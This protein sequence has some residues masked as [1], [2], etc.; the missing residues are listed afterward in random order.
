MNLNG[1]C[2]MYGAKLVF[3][4]AGLVMAGWQSASAAAV[5]NERAGRELKAARE[6]LHELHREAEELQ[7]AGRNDKAEAVMEKA[8]QLELRLHRHLERQKEQK[9]EHG[10]N[11][12]ATLERLEQ[13]MAALREL[14]M[15]DELERLEHIA[16]GLRE[17]LRHQAERHRNEDEEHAAGRRQL[18]VMRMAFEALMEA[19]HERAVEQLERGIHALEMALE[20]R[21]DE[22]A[23]RMREHAPSRGQIAEILMLAERLLRERGREERAATV[24]KFARQLAGQ[25]R[26]RGPANERKMALRNL[27]IMRYALEALAEAERPDAADL[28]ERALRVREMALEGRR[29]EEARR[30]RAGAPDAPQLVELLGMATEILEDRGRTERAEAVAQLA[31]QARER[32]GGDRPRPDQHDR[33]D[34]VQ[35]FMERVETLE[36]R[37][38][39][40]ERA[41]ERIQRAIESLKHDGD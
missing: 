7:E 40:M 31:R 24:G 39:G 32:L 35:R 27:K 18:G 41:M 23:N 25:A 15:R 10:G 20:G 8:H 5:Q 22:E 17:R 16:A 19:G 37:L 12:E 28:I 21:R 4:T 14:G 1:H 6:R 33:P 38:T 3:M 34:G 9:R 11:L 30:M 36:E 29:D 26:R 2:R 13:G